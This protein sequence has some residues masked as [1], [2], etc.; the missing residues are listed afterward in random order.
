MFWK[1][2]T[3][4]QKKRGMHFI[5]N[6]NSLLPKIDEVCY[7]GNIINVSQKQSSRGVSRQ[8]CFENMQQIYR[9]TL[10]LKCDFKKLQSDFIEITL[11]HECSP[12]NLLHIFRTPFSKNT[13]WWLLLV[14]VIGISETKLG[15][16]IF[17]SEL[18]VDGYY[19]IKLISQ[20]FGFACCI[21]FDDI[22][23]HEDSFCSNFD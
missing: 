6:V 19:S 2:A 21:K 23:S 8:R 16:T 7:I 1:Y 10:M 22:Y 15:K 18:E 11:Q 4:F 12:V 3:N 20:C 5:P 14:S 9:R 17:S 13:T